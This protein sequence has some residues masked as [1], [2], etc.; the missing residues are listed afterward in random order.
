MSAVS[1]SDDDLRH[2]PP[3]GFVPFRIGNGQDFLTLTGPFHVR[4]KD[5]HLSL[6]FRIEPKHCNI[7]GVCH[8]GMLLTF[9]DIQMAIAAKHQGGLSGFQ[10]T[11]GL[12]ADFLGGAPRGAWLAGRTDIVKVTEGFVFTQCLITADQAPVLRASGSFKMAKATPELEAAMRLRL[13]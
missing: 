10:P 3:L 13:D 1:A 12:A 4:I 8:G 7:A 9:A 11:V 2:A 5:G 6:G